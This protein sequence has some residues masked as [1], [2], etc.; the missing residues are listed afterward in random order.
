MLLILFA[1]YSPDETLPHRILEYVKELCSLPGEK[2]IKVI[3][4]TPSHIRH[5][6]WPLNVELVLDKNEGL[7]FGLWFRY[8]NRMDD[9]KLATY[10]SVL[11]VNDSCTVTGS[12]VPMWMRM[13]SS[14][15]WGVTDS[16]EKGVHHLQSYFL[17]F[18]NDAVS[19]L[20]QF[21]STSLST[22]GFSKEKII[23]AREVAISQFMIRNRG[24]NINA[25][26]P[27]KSIKNSLGIGFLKSKNSSLSSFDQLQV[28]G[29]KLLKRTRENR[30]EVWKINIIILVVVFLT[31]LSIIGTT[32]KHKRQ[33][34]PQTNSV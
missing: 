23:K 19:A 30:K 34:I 2:L 6:E 32:L 1:V 12:L 10:S 22:E 31:T 5:S 29:C 9:P 8:I 16:Y 24:F 17:V 25:A 20:S 33:T 13:N 3:T 28:M 18:N 27:Y 7:D 4:S 11:L 15:F 14:E 21:I 26:F